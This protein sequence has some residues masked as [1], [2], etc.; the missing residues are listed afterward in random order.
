MAKNKIVTIG[1]LSAVGLVKT[2]GKYRFTLR[3]CSPGN[4]TYHFNLSREKAL[5]VANGNEEFPLSSQMKVSGVILYTNTLGYVKILAV[6]GIETNAWS[7]RVGS[8]TVESGILSVA[9]NRI[10]EAERAEESMANRA[11][12]TQPAAIT[13]PGEAY[14]NAMSIVRRQRRLKNPKL[15]QQEIWQVRDALNLLA[16]K[17]GIA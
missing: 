5:Q 17:L 16:E 6:D 3:E 11:S 2:T 1:K 12:P 10:K 13:D 4:T 15:S 7:Q 8:V 14:E 9:K